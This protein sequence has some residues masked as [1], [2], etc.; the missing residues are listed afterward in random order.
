[1]GLGTCSAAAGILVAALLGVQ[2]A[3]RHRHSVPEVKKIRQRS[4]THMPDQTLY[5]LSAVKA[6]QHEEDQQF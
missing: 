2:P 6:K 1:M 5:G 3:P 4:L